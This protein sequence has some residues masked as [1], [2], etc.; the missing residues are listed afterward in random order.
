MF[1]MAIE[2]IVR[3]KFRLHLGGTTLLKIS[4]DFTYICQSTSHM[5]CIFWF[6]TTAMELFHL[7]GPHSNWQAPKLLEAL[8]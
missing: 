6:A 3:Y 8:L 2:Q 5:P 4:L 1:N 7:K